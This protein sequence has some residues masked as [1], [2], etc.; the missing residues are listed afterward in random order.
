MPTGGSS[1]RRPPVFAGEEGQQV[2]LVTVPAFST[3]QTACLVNLH[4]LNCQP[5]SFSGFGAEDD[6]GD[7]EVGH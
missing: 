7:M 2:L 5:I 1:A 4:D 6:E 3:T